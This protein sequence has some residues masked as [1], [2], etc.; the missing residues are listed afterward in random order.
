MHPVPRGKRWYLKHALH[1]A[2][3][4]GRLSYRVPLR[5]CFCRCC[6][7]GRQPSAGIIA[8]VNVLLLKAWLN[9]NATSL[10]GA[11]LLDVRQYDAR[12]FILRL[13]LE[14]VQHE[15]LVSVLE[16]CPILAI[17]T[18]TPLP[19]T[20][21]AP[22]SNFVKALRFHL[23]GY[24]LMSV[25]QPGFER[26]VSFTFSQK[27]MYGRTSVKVLTVE[28]AGRSSNAFLITSQRMVISIFKRVRHGQN[29]VR[30]VM[31]GKMFPDPPPLGKFIAAESTVA[32]LGDEL[33]RCSSSVDGSGDALE[34]LLS[35]RVAGGDVRL[36][37]HLTHLLPVEYTLDSL[38]KFILNFQRGDLT[39]AL[40]GL[41]TAGATANSVA[42]ESWREAR[43]ERRSHTPAPSGKPELLA[44]K[45]SQL[46]EQQLQA[47]RAD[48]L[49]ALA[50]EMLRQAR[51]LD[52]RG[53]A[54]GFLAAWSAEYPDWA[55][56][57]NVERSAY[58]N[59]QELI[60]LAQRLKRGSEKLET[61]IAQVQQ[62]LEALASAPPQP[63]A[64]A[65]SAEDKYQRDYSR[66]RKLDLKYLRFQ[67]TD[68]IPILCGVSDRSNDG[69]L[70]A[71]GHARHLWFHARDYPGSHV[72]LLTNGE[73]PPY[74]SLEQAAVVAAYHSQGRGELEL[75][76]SYLPMKHLRRPRDAKP[77]QVLKSSEKVINVRPA[78]FEELRQALYVEP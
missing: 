41:G 78:A 75:D 10:I 50:L 27:D 77:G 6:V 73:E 18:D 12:S 70:R 47:S 13:T 37:P 64:E 52:A 31:T 72:I 24:Q 42:L 14:S 34:E 54:A 51:D 44:S 39:S 43:R 32:Q 11:R 56:Y 36:W 65:E 33:A 17:T 3:G 9:S 68:G 55:Q 49:E 61:A 15:L 4:S 69:L 74:S 53:E 62:Q 25:V 23:S 38:Y 40:F 8:S 46:Q 57:L 67:S 63:A 7:A 71:F 35:R 48:E 21:A 76:V 2:A 66:L 19:D 60:H 45:L 29:R 28:L 16:D 1:L 58:D 30:H 20:P 59:S 22:E 5:R 26:S